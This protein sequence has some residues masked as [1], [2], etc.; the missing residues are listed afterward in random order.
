L[1]ATFQTKGPALAI[2]KG[3]DRDRA[4]DESGNQVAVFGRR[5]AR[6]FTLEE[7]Q[8]MYLT[9][10]GQVFTVTDISRLDEKTPLPRVQNS[11]APKAAESSPAQPKI[12]GAIK[13][14][15]PVSGKMKAGV[16]VGGLGLVFAL[17]GW[18]KLRRPRRYR[19]KPAA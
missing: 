8:R 11:L 14:T 3:L 10:G 9:K 2:S 5:G 6:P 12:T 4:V 17:I 18:R 1:I 19:R 16:I 13:T 15:R 7:M